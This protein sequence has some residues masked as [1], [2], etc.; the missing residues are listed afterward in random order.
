MVYAAERESDGLRVAIKTARYDQAG[1]SERLVREIEHLRAVAPP[2]VPAV[3]HSGQLADGTAFAVLEFVVAPTLADELTNGAVPFKPD[4]FKVRADAMLSSI[5]AIHARGRVHCDLKPENI[6]IES[7]PV[8]ARVFDFGLA[9]LGSDAGGSAP[10]GIE[11]TAEYMSPEQCREDA[12]LDCRADLYALGVIFY[13]MLTGAVPFFGTAADVQESHRSK[14]P[15]RPSTLVPVPPSIEEVVLR[16]LAKEPQQR[17]GSVAELRTSLDAAMA[18]ANEAPAADAAPKA[19]SPAAAPTREKR[20]MGMVFF[21]SS[22]DAAS[23]Q[24]VLTSFG[25]HLAHAAGGSYVGV[26][27]HDTGDN[28]ARRALLAGRALIGHNLTERALVDLGQVTIQP[29]PG[30]GKRYISALFTRADRFPNASDPAGVLVTEASSKMLDDLATV[31]IAGRPGVFRVSAAGDQVQE[32]ATIVKQGAGPLVGR[33]DVLDALVASARGALERK[34]PTIA[35]VIAEPGHGKSHLCATLIERL[36]ATSFGGQLLQLRARE[37]VGGDADQTLRELLTKVLRIPSDH[38]SD[39]GHTL[40]ADRLGPELG[41]EVWPGVALVFGWVAADAPELRGLAAAPGVLRAAAARAAAAALKRWASEKPLL[42]V[43]DDAQFADEATLDAIELA[44]LAEANAPIWTCVLGRPAFESGRPNWAERCSERQMVRLGPLSAESAVELCR[45]LLLPAQNVPADAIQRLV[46][47]THGVPLLLVELVRALKG[48][49]LIRQDNRTRAWYLATDEL[50]RLPDLPLVEWL[51]SRELESLSPDLA[52]HARLAALLGAEFKPIE[53]AGVVQELELRGGAQAFPLDPAVGTQ[54]L[55]TGGILI[56]RRHGQL[57]F[58]HALVREAVYKAVPEAMRLPIHEA[59]LDYYR[60]E[61]CELP[62]GER[63]P[64][65]GFHAARSGRRDEAM[66][67]FLSLAERAQARHAYLEA[68]LMYTQAIEQMAANGQ[69]KRMSAC[70]GRGLMR[71]RLGRYADACKDFEIARDTAHQLE[72]FETEVEVLLDEATA[73]DWADEYRRS[74]EL[75]EKAQALAERAKTPLIDARLLMGLGRSSF[76][77]SRDAEAA[78][79]LDQAAE[80]AEPLGDAGYETFVISLL[81]NGYV[82]AT[83]GRLDDSERAFDRVIPLCAERGDKL[84][85]GAAVGNRF[86]LWTCRNEKDRLIADLERLLQISREMGNGRMEQQAHFYL[87][88]FQRWL[89]NFEEAEKHARR[90]VEIDERRFGEAARP[91]SHLLLARVLSARGESTAARAILTEIRARQ[92]RARERN[93]REI[94]LLPSE[95]AFFTMVD[96]ATRQAEDPEWDS[97]QAHASSCL[98]GQDL[99][100]VLEMRARAAQHQ[101]RQAQARKAFEEALGIAK[102]VP[103]VMRERIERELAAIGAAE[104]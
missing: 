5:A 27:G 58:R 36:Q 44:T 95:E 7:A 31:P 14:R 21:A 48:E 59:A 49:G 101:R 25:G 45:T 4:A 91:E 62:E 51:A 8:R 70:R 79:L 20:T 38:P 47:R 46:D 15:P 39:G 75:V 99:I 76:R 42:F 104:A 80:R 100:E 103:N 57:S 61:R 96:L 18:R 84:H 9:R 72:N 97:L 37:P 92:A 86:M 24:S 12:A 81:L 41:K 50:N 64:R 54:R 77:F 68:E 22:S 52:A 102:R 10:V 3:H 66:A 98:T 53:I 17:F 88:V 30:G 19:S 6:F 87:G 93:D 26:F 94:E 67:A 63:L 11:G 34:V 33:D 40:L 29:R 71:Y 83:L 35:T 89:H 82:L 1:A 32:Q 16:C 43:L 55:L 73:L 60:G 28:P 90:A 56:A 78:Q 13:E 85:L 74:N 69:A 65:L 23:I 2:Y